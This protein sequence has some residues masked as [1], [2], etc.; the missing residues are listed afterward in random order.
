[1]GKSVNRDKMLDRKMSR[2]DQRNLEVSNAD[3]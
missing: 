2:I 3:F 1:M